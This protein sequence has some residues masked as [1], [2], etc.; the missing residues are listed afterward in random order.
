MTT[1]K[2]KLL[3]VAGQLL[4][5]KQRIESEQEAKRRLKSARK[6]GLKSYYQCR[7]C[8]SW[9]LTSKRESERR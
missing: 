2:K 1:R 9:H 5:M 7:V 6:A 3:K 8:G 4:C